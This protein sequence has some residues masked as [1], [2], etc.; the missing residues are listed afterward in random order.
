MLRLIR[1]LRA[2]FQ[3]LPPPMRTMIELLPLVI[4]LSAFLNLPRVGREA[5][6]SVTL[7]EFFGDADTLAILGLIGVATVGIVGMA[8]L[9]Y[10]FSQ[11]TW[12]DPREAL[13]RDEL[14]PESENNA[15]G[16]TASE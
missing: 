12:D 5:V 11:A 14:A 3:K 13:Y 6:N 10:L 2:Q 7:S 1:A 15:A 16:T 9:I 4:A 8:W